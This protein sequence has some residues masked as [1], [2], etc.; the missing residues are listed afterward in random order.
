MAPT[1]NSRMIRCNYFI[2]VHF[3]HAGITMGS[4]I[5]DIV[6]NLII[7]PPHVDKTTLISTPYQGWAPTQL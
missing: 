5:P 2:E 1:T 7:N 4:H 6:M 3:E